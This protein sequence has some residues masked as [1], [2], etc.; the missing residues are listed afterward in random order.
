M[1]ESPHKLVFDWGTLCRYARG[2]W[3]RSPEGAAVSYDGLGNQFLWHPSSAGLLRCALDV[4][5]LST[6]PPEILRPR[7]M[8]DESFFA[9]WTSA[10][11]L[12]KLS[13][14]PILIW[15]QRNGL[16]DRATRTLP[17]VSLSSGS[18]ARC[19][20]FV[21]PECNVIFSCGLAASA[22]ES[23]TQS[24]RIPGSRIYARN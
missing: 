2:E 1:A 10:E 14:L 5:S 16:R 8:T 9:A 13:D 4:E 19:R 3:Q 7:G 6:K 21:W 18:V 15:L 12:A 17:T 22:G 11:V 20:C 24:A 23:S